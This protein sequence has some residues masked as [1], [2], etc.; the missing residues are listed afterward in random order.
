MN[1]AM[2]SLK[3][4]QGR[5]WAHERGLRQNELFDQNL[6]GSFNAR[7]F[8][9][10]MHMIVSNFEFLCLSLAIL[11]Q[12]HDTNMRYAIPVQIKVVVM[13]YRLATGSSMQSIAGLYMIDLFTSQLAVSE[14]NIAV[15]KLLLKKFIGWPSTTI[16]EKFAKKNLKFT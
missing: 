8:K 6:L 11:L 7:A 5:L 4:M 9:G 14:F 10:R 3:R 12:S 16:M 13:I 2:R 1:L 15:N